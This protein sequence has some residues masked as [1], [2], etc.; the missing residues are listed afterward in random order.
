MSLRKALHQQHDG[1]KIVCD[2]KAL[3]DYA[4]RIARE[5]GSALSQSKQRDGCWELSISE[6]ALKRRQRLRQRNPAE[7]D[8][9]D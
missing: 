6:G 9:A 2:T 8:E 5:H 3:A 4:A 7:R 1:G